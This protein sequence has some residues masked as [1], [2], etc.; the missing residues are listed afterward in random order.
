MKVRDHDVMV[1]ENAVLIC[2]TPIA[3]FGSAE[4][5]SP[6]QGGKYWRQGDVSRLI[7]I[8]HDG[9]QRLALIIVPVAVFMLELQEDLFTGAP[10]RL[11][12]C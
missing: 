1:F 6:L 9:E 2:R 12:P 10:L 7:V 8:E 11:Q 5:T 3:K 4:T